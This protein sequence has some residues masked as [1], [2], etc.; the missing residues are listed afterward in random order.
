LGESFQRFVRSDLLFHN[1][2]LYIF[3]CVIGLRSK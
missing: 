1:P 2:V 3:F